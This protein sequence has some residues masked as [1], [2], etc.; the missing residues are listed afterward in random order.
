MVWHEL[1]YKCWFDVTAQLQELKE[2][3]VVKEEIKIDDHHSYILSKNGPVI[4]CRVAD[5]E[6]AGDEDDDDDEADADDDADDD[7]SVSLSIHAP[8]KEK[9]PKFIFKPVRQ[10]LD[11]AKILRGEYSLAYM[12]GEENA[13]GEAT[14]VAAGAAG[15]CGS[16]SSSSGGRVLGQH[17]GQDIVIKSGKYGAYVAWGGQNISLRP[18]LGISSSK[19]G[20][21]ARKETKQTKSEFDLTLQEVVAF[22]NSSRGGPAPESECDG[23]GESAAAVTSTTGII[24]M[25]D[26]HTS[27]RNGRFGPYIFYKT[28]KM[29]KPEFIPLKGFAQLHGNYATCD[30]SL[31][32][33]WVAGARKK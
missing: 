13:A 6:D 30:I 7:D 9:K 29:S 26:E 10:D 14:T 18:L 27:I 12:I 17:Q 24:R 16:S 5:D 22:I 15:T 28:V 8:T 32:K 3:G 21:Y 31:L 19:A 11:Y 1:C 2:R 25:I 4:R 23:G 33:E 20:K